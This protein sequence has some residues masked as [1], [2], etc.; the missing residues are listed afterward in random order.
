MQRIAP[1]IARKCPPKFPITKSMFYISASSFSSSSS[2]NYYLRKRRKWP[3]K[4]YKQQWLQSFSHQLAVQSFKKSI[5]KGETR[6]LSS[7]LQSFSTYQIDP[8]PKAYR[9]L[10]KFL[11]QR[12][13]LFGHQIPQI[14]DHIEKAESF[15]TPE[16]VF[17]DLIDFY[18]EN[19]MLNEA[20]ELFFR[21]PKFRCEPSVEA[22]NALLSVICRGKR[23]LE[24]VPQ[25][26]L[27][28]RDMNI[29]IE[30]SSYGILIRALCK[31]GR[32]SQALELLKYMVEDGFSAD[33]K[34]C[35]LML[36]T[37]CNHMDN[38]ID[39]VMG[40]LEDLK[41]LGFEPRMVDFSILIRVL[42]KRGKIVDALGVFKQMKKSRLRPDIMCYNLILS[43]LIFEWDFSRAD[44]VFDELLLV[45][46]IPDI[47]T[48]NLY[49][50]CLCT[51]NKIEDGI[52]MLGSMEELGCAPKLSTYITV[53]KALCEAGELDRVRE[54]MKG[55]RKK[56]I[57]LDSESYEIMIHGLISYGDINEAH[58]LL[59]EMFDDNYVLQLTSLDRII[60][61]LY[62]MGLFFNATELLNEVGFKGYRS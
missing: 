32:V 35:S 37:M 1:E 31:I 34:I 23:G 19:N 59:N 12:H 9:F 13:R 29:R 43:G 3:L 20:V 26:L 8:S 45:G 36:A 2:S 62:K 40:F 14:L 6:L 18:G 52:K 30:D 53:L 17:I 11:T 5:K 47:H 25:I 49:I 4:S 58:S 21:I 39:E 57:N 48:Y 60:C 15:E 50:N 42:V 54:V 33:Q 44:K 10:F 7:L 38:N 61:R 55:M 46:L 41:T 28:T 27:K 22:L 16:C 51:Q 56:G 24:I